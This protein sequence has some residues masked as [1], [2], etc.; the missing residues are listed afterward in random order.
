M[1]KSTSP[2]IRTWIKSLT[3]KRDLVGY[4]SLLSTYIHTNDSNIVVVIIIIINNNNNNNFFL[5]SLIVESLLLLPYSGYDVY[6]P[7]KVLVTHDYHGHQNNPVVHTWGRAH[8]HGHKGDDGDEQDKGLPSTDWKWNKEIEDAR[9]AWSVF[10]SRRVNM[11]LGLGSKFDSTRKERQEVE[12]IRRSRF[13]LGTKRTLKQVREFTGIN[14][15]EEKME[16]NRCGNLVWVPYAESIDY[17][18]PQFF[19][20]GYDGKA[21]LVLDQEEEKEEPLL[22]Q[23]VS[24][25][26]NINN[27]A[28]I[29]S[30]GGLRVAAVAA[31]ELS[32]TSTTTFFDYRMSCGL[33]LLVV[34]VL[35]RLAVQRKKDERKKI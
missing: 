1:P 24:D 2:W 35:L 11:L 4:D 28:A 33:L 14:L 25:T 21:E 20:R 9:D 27:A 10:G 26:N 8:N 12:R 23:V 29:P 18:L 7:D 5:P 30:S 16:V 6:T 31:S 34:V 15:L 32:P 22:H 19:A 13:G 3:E 17:G